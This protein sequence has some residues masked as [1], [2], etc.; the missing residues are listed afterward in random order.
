MTDIKKDKIKRLQNTMIN[1]VRVKYF[2]H[3]TPSNLTL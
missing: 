2:I 3:I 1:D